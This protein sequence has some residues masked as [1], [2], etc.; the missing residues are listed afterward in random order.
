LKCVRMCI[1]KYLM[2]GAFR[3]VVRMLA[4][5]R[6]LWGWLLALRAMLVGAC[7]GGR[8]VQVSA[9][10]CRDKSGDAVTLS[11]G[12]TTIPVPV[13]EGADRVED[14]PVI[15]LVASPNIGE[16]A[17][18]LASRS[19]KRFWV[20]ARYISYGVL[21]ELLDSLDSETE[22]RII[23]GDSKSWRE[24]EKILS[25][26]S[27]DVS[28][29]FRSRV[30]CKLY[31]NDTEV[32]ITSA[33]ATEAGFRTQ[34]ELGVLTNDPS[35]VG[36]VQEFFDY[37]CE[38]RPKYEENPLLP[39]DKVNSP[40]ES[41]FGTSFGNLPPVELLRAAKHKIVVVSPF[42]S[43]GAALK[44]FELV[45]RGVEIVFVTAIAEDWDRNFDPHGVSEL[46]KRGV[47]VWNN[48]RLHAKAIMVDDDRALVSSMNLTNYG[49]RQNVEAGLLTQHRDMISQLSDYVESLKEEEVDRDEFNRR[50]DGF[51]K[52]RGPKILDTVDD[53]IEEE[54]IGSI[55]LGER[56]TDDFA[57]PE[58]KG[59][60]L[61][62]EGSS[63][64][65]PP[66]RRPKKMPHG[67]TRP[68]M[69]G[70]KDK[71]TGPRVEGPGYDWGRF[72]G[73]ILARLELKG[74]KRSRVVA[75]VV[76][77]RGARNPSLV[78]ETKHRF[79]EVG[80]KKPRGKLL[81]IMSNLGL[82]LGDIQR[83]VSW[84]RQVPGRPLKHR[85]VSEH[86]AD[87]PTPIPLS[88]PDELEE[89]VR[90]ELKQGHHA[91]ALEFSWD[92]RAGFERTLRRV[93]MDLSLGRVET[94]DTVGG[95]GT[96][97][98]TYRRDPSQS[99]RIG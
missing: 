62:L 49:L 3:G 74:I 19:G 95:A 15:R 23:V 13:V 84:L 57:Y 52:R 82:A 58:L 90:G 35:I 33:N 96:R 10:V 38:R 46:L 9:E 97:R 92:Q 39:T 70:K 94:L 83:I 75:S 22:V 77:N 89:I 72:S 80:S 44:L 78:F 51:V 5:V 43:Y 54:E 14:S 36:K 48:P 91:F 37:L 64:P 68:K 12:T 50:V 93:E 34:K 4:L 20:V 71:K 59:A 40:T 16:E 21:K 67:S 25:S 29:I 26:M 88:S 2:W 81:T 24:A 69:P 7:V 47:K 98:V 41:M 60:D 76:H 42:V 11:Q 32:M 61:R 73:V 30:H 53:A 85:V 8:E 28:L 6:R 31:L 99:E 56:P 18:G 79:I 86:T 17:I 65:Y 27:G 45:E 87:V 63:G 66:P 55:D 1:H